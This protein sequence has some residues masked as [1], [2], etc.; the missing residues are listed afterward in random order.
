MIRGFVL[1]SGLIVAV[2]GIVLLLWLLWILWKFKTVEPEPPAIE[3]GA[4]ETESEIEPTERVE[5]EISSAAE[6][7]NQAL[8]DTIEAEREEE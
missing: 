2:A 3:T 8:Q 1:L 5:A 6:E 4:S 7:G